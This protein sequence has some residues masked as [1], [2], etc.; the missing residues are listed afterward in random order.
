M[1]HRLLPALELGEAEGGPAR[2][3]AVAGELVNIGTAIRGCTLPA[4]RRP[5]PFLYTY[6]DL[7]GPLR[8]DKSQADP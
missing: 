7:G 6:F 2:A 4:A 3:R 5:I 8:V 1:D